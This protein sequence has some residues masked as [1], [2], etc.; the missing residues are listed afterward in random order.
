MRCEI[1]LKKL[2]AF[3]TGELSGREINGVEVHLGSC[4][5]CAHEL[6]GLQRLAGYVRGLHSSAPEDIVGKV[7]ESTGDGYGLIETDL[8]RIWVGFNR[9]GITMVHPK[10]RTSE[11]FESLYQKRIGRRPIP[12]AIPAA[13]LH[14]VE[15]AVAGKGSSCAVLDLSGLSSFERRVLLLLRQIPR[16]EV[17]PYGWL[18]REAGSPRAVRAVG[19]TMARN[20]L[21]LLLPCHRVVPAGGGIGNYAFGSSFKR[22]LL[23][24]EKAPVREIELLAAQGVRF[25]GC[26]STRV[27]C[28]PTCRDARRIKLENRVPFHSLVEAGAA[29]YRP[30]R[31]C[32]PGS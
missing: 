13:H 8:G 21:P 15:Q 25:V 14:S 3:R 2:D 11:T 26:R 22:E 20:P 30:C 19:N 4:E 17:R 28:F 27:Y 16:G 7:V 23:R 24:R 32:R 12:C 10:S 9:R 31:H 5:S 6:V 18:A 29:G 1:V